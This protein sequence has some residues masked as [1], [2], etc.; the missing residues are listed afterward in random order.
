[1]MTVQGSKCFLSR[2]GSHSLFLH[3]APPLPLPFPLSREAWEDLGW[4]QRCWESRLGFGPT[5]SH[6]LPCKS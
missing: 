1:M 6:S 3:P 5:S 2:K 4:M